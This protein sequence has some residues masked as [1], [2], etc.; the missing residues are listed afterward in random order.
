VKKQ[1]LDLDQ[2]RRRQAALESDVVRLKGVAAQRVLLE[3]Q[4][5]SQ[6]AQL[7]SLESQMPAGKNADEFIRMLQGAAVKS[8]VH[9]RRIT[10]KP[11]MAREFHYEMPLEVEAEGSYFGLLDLFTALSHMTRI[12][13]VGDLTLAGYA[14]GLA[15]PRGAPSGATVKATFT[16]TTFFTHAEDSGIPPAQVLQPKLPAR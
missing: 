9:L 4:V 11:V 7:E 1:R 3:P 2:A 8:G 16:V 6:R 12:N 5:E 14:A 13:N 15:R 10:C